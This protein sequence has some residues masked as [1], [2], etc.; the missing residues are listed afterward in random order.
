MSW[1]LGLESSCD[2]TGVSEV[3]EEQNESKG[4]IYIT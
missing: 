4:N 2:V 1:I 3:S